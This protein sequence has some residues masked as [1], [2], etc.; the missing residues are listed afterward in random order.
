MK[1]GGGN[2]EYMLIGGSRERVA[3]QLDYLGSYQRLRYMKP[4]VNG[5]VEFNGMVDRKY[6]Y[7]D[8]HKARDSEKSY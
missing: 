5:A 8:F 6:K 3:K 1:L 4:K 7:P 2:N